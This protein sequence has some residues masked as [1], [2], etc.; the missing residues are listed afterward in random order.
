M[1]RGVI[2]DL[3]GVLVTTDEFHYLAWKRLAEEE[4]IP[5]D[6][7]VQR[8]QR[9]VGRMD[10]LEVMLERAPRAYSQEEKVA[11]AER[12]NGYYRQSL[13]KLSPA[14]LLPGAT[15]AL[16]KLRQRGIK[17]AIASSS[18]NTPLIIERVVLVGKVDAV[19]DGNDITHSKPH[20]EVF[21]LSA[22]RM[23]LTAEHC[24]VVEDAPAGIEAGRRAGMAVFGIGTP[25][26]LPGVEH[27][28]PGLADVTVDELL[29]A[30]IHD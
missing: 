19:V 4:G 14:D 11:M 20:P 9:G 22:E 5:Y 15:E 23:G 21:L 16:D 10:S 3:D 13:Q 12:K 25:D 18:K 2:F 7:E 17:T 26:R 1:I 30:G 6:R 27:L 28:A 8:R 29:A 24:L